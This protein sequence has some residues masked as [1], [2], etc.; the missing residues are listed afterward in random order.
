MLRPV[1]QQPQEKALPEKARGQLWLFIFPSPEGRT[2]CCGRGGVVTGFVPL[3]RAV[4]LLQ[5]ET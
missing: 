5:L 4:K 1:L 2:Q 3:Q